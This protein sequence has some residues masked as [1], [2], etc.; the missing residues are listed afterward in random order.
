MPPPPT[1]KKSTIFISPLLF[2]GLFFGMHDLSV[3][4]EGL[5][6][7]FASALLEDFVLGLELSLASLELAL[8][9]ATFLTS[10]FL[11]SLRVPCNSGDSSF[12]RNMPG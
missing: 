11:H 4:L 7:S 12:N 9:A 6:F 10:C 1:P 2:I 5:D 3:L 8:V